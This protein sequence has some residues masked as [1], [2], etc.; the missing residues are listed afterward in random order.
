MKFLYLSFF[1]YFILYI[2]KSD[3]ETY[4]KLNDN[5]IKNKYSVRILKKSTVECG[6][7]LNDL[8]TIHIRTFSPGIDIM[9]NVLSG[10]KFG[11]AEQTFIVGKHNVTPLNKGL[12]GM[13]V[14]ELRRIGIRI[15][16]IGKIYYEVTLKDYKKND[17]INEEL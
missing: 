9:P 3:D 2:V 16:N 5:E 15:G 6:L 8:A 4:I 7:K 1:F 14:G 13:C 11:Y 10:Y 12:I 17:V